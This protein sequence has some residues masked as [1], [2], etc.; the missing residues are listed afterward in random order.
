MDV[1]RVAIVKSLAVAV[2]FSIAAFCLKQELFAVVLAPKDDEFVTYRLLDRMAA[3]AG[4]AV[5]P[6]SVR[7]INTG[8]A[9]QF[10]IHMKTVGGGYAMFDVFTLSLVALPMWVL[11]EI[12]ILIVKT[13]RR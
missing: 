10:V 12:N 11:Y 8:L 9:Q 13:N 3:W 4:G 7:L 2:V 1:L 5:E 6:F